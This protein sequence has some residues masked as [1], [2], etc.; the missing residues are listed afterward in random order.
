ML[1][2]F[3]DVTARLCLVVGGGPVGRRKAAALLDAGAR[4]CLVCLEPRPPDLTAPALDWLQQPYQPEHLDG[5][6]LVIAAAPPEVNRQ[7][8]IDAHARGLWV[9]AASQPRQG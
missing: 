9:N 8:A 5:V 4:V 7:V 6:G 2:L 1:P 3:L